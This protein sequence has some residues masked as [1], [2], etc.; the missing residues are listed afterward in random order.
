[1]SLETTVS[2]RE[3]FVKDV[4]EFVALIHQITRQWFPEEP[5]WGPWFRGQS[6]ANWNLLPK[7]YRRSPTHR[8]MR[9]VEDELRQEF[10]MRA[11]GLTGLGEER[12]PNSWEWYFVM[13]HCGAPTRLLDWTEGALLA[14]YFAVRDSGTA[15]AAVWILDPWWLNMRV[16]GE[17]EVVAPGATVGISARDAQRYR[18]WLP[19]R[20][21]GANIPELPIA[22]YPSHTVRR[23]STQRSCFTVHGS[24]T[25]VFD[26]LGNE[27]EAHL[28][29]ITVPRSS[30][31]LIK[32]QLVICGVDEVTIFPDVDGL[33]RLLST[34][35]E[36]EKNQE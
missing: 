11:P 4:P 26:K 21:E 28:L 3:G 31:P 5:N 25:D 12:P 32:E 19:D 34:M 29:R 2:M 35:L 7:M 9:I 33:G 15:D 30:V 36:T 1:M 18:P 16:V 23:I 24:S 14:M 27:N 13:Q 22:V 6:Q 17:R 10:A 8:S 20:Y